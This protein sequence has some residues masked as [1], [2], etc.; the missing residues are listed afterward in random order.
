MAVM[1]I[2]T[3]LVFLWTGLAPLVNVTVESVLH[4]LLPMVMALIGGITVYAQRQYFPLAAQVMGTFQSFKLL[5]TIVQTIVRPRGHLFKVTPKGNATSGTGYERGIFWT[6]L[7]LMIATMAGMVINA[8]PDWRI[9]E[10]AALVPLVAFWST[11]NVVVLFLVC[12][13]CLQAP[14]RRSEE[15]FEITESAWLERA[16][17]VLHRCTTKDL[18]LSGLGLELAGS[19]AIAVPPGEHVRVFIKSVGFI[20]GKV[21]R[22]HDRQIGVQFHLPPSIE[23]DLL[24]RKIFTSGYDTTAVATTTWAATIALL[25]RI[26][27]VQ[28]DA[29]RPQPAVERPAPVELLPA[30]TLVVCPTGQTLSLANLSYRRER[31][32]S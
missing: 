27:T 12:M 20:A 14:V 8:M 3:P 13:M 10:Q 9:V 32:V 17:T 26:W 11:V 2:L 24:I 15:R 28:S 19:N 22:A 5:P 4:Y 16:D 29:G 30:Q 1:S 25:R 23:R 18:S 6:G 31:L 21:A 7:T